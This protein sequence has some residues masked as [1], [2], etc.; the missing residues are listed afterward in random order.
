MN[1]LS[2]FKKL[3]AGNQDEVASSDRFE[4]VL[5]G[6]G[7]QGMILAGK[8]LAEA[9]TIFD[10]KVAVMS[11]S[12]GPEARGGASRAEVIISPGNIDYPKVMDVDILLCMTQE[13]MDKYGQM[14]SPEGLLIAD[15]T[16]VKNIP[17]N[18]KHVFKAPFTLAAIKILDTPI[19]ANVIALGAMAAITKVVSREALI[20][21]VLDL[22]TK[23][24]VV[25]DRIAVDTGYMIAKDSGFQWSIKKDLLNENTR[26]SGS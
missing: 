3:K 18:F 25:M 22:V 24:V 7:G 20:R 2:L 23:K 16:F 26:V 15:D 8:I 21:A 9:A 12:Y 13:S 10:N 6:S 1:I 19:V 14:L 4:I 11:Q 5:S 17:Y